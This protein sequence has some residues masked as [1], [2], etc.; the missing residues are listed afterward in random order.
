MWLQQGCCR[1]HPLCC[2]RRHW[3]QICEET[4]K[5]LRDPRLTLQDLV[6]MDMLTHMPIL[7]DVLRQAIEQGRIEQAIEQMKRYAVETL[8]RGSGASSL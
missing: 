8:S 7:E 4:G 1:Y 3:V 6:G 5:N 2:N